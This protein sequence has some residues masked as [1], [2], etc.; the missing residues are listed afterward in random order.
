MK[1][2]WIPDTKGFI[3]IAVVGSFVVAVFIWMLFPP[4]KIDQAALTV[5]NM[6]LGALVAKFGTIVDFNFGSSQGSKD[7]DDAQNKVVE[8]LATG[9]V[10][11]KV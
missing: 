9:V 5:V 1:P 6:L 7:K 8:K 4:T 3:A 10:E 2:N 11:P